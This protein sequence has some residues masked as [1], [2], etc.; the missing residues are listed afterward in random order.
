MFRST[1][2]ETLIDHDGAESSQLTKLG[3]ATEEVVRACYPSPP[4]STKVLADCRRNF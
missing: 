4:G 3:Q 1:S 2:K